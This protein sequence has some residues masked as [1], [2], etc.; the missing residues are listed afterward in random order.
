MNPNTINEAIP[1]QVA[2]DAENEKI[3]KIL[4]DACRTKL[5]TKKENPLTPLVNNLLNNQNK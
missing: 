2:Q 3:S 4:A 1:D 5:I